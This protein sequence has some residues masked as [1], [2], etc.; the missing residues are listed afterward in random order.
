VPKQVVQLW[1][2]VHQRR[3]LVKNIFNLRVNVDSYL[4][5]MWAGE[6]FSITLQDI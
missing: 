2:Q 3:E 4:L 6:V 1:F 5:A